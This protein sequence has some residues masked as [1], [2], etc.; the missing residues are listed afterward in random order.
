MA[1]QYSPKVITS[2]LTLLLDAGD[3]NSYPRSGTT[4]YD[5]SNS[6]KNV[7]LVNGPSFNSANSGY[8][9]F[10]GSD[11]YGSIAG[12]FYAITLGNGELSW[13]TTAWVKTSTSADGLGQGSVISNSSG[14]P[15]Y[16][17]MGLN[18]GRIVYWSYHPSLGGWYRNLG[19]TTINNNAWHML[20]WVN[21]GNS[22][23]Q[24]YV[25][26]V[27]DSSTF[28]SLSGN[29]NPLDIIGGSWAG[30]FAGSIACLSINKGFA[31]SSSQ[32]VQNYQAQKT[33]FGL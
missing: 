6:G 2:G 26:G 19:N 22:T 14:G 10:D 4:W 1:L 8:F 29:N 11:D 16:S 30:R 18:T 27:L 33:R 17:M 28:S 15:V 23:M 25:D 21:Y 20:T 12:G 24:M 9:S 13:T 3:V 31:L 32:V 7:T 5:V